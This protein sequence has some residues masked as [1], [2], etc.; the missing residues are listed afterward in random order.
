MWCAREHRFG[1]LTCMNL[2]L[3]VFVFHYSGENHG[4]GNER[5]LW[6][7]WVGRCH[8]CTKRTGMPEGIFCANFG[9]PVY[10]RPPCHHTWCAHCYCESHL[11]PF[12]AFRA[13]GSDD[14]ELELNET[15]RM[16]YKTAR[17]GDTVMCP[18]ECD[19]CEFYKLDHRAPDSSRDR[20]NRIMA[21]I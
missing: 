15:E 8:V 20:D 18:F 14:Q 2:Y 3:L 1:Q 19:F 5:R 6:W 10:G 7:R 11:I 12:S 17:P 16:R 13:K 4:F 9:Q 21:L